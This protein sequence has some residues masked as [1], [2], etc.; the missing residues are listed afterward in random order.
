MIIEKLPISKL[1]LLKPQLLNDSRGYFFR[2]FCKQELVNIGIAIDEVVQVNRSFN[3]KKGTFRGLHYQLPPFSEEKIVSCVQG[4]VADIV[5]DL[6]KNSPTFLEHQLLELSSENKHSILIPKGC[7][8]GFIT[9]EDNAEL[10]YM[11]TSFYNQQA[12]SACSVF[13]PMLNI[14]LPIEIKEISERDNS[15]N[16]LSID[17][18]GITI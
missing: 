4:S 16:F 7:A 14:N 17:F 3:K 8:H 9:L 2:E 10:L 13:D 1:Y 15:H 6:R 11:H 18:K 12:E 5:V